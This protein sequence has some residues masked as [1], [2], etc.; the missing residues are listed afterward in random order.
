MSAITARTPAGRTER[1]GLDLLPAPRIS[2]DLG[3]HDIASALPAA[4][5]GIVQ[6]GLLDRAFQDSLYPE[7]IFPNV[8]DVMPWV[9]NVGD[10]KIWTRTGLMTPTP[11]PVAPGADAAADTYSMEQWKSI[12]DTYGRSIDTNVLQSAVSLGNKYLQDVMTLGV[13]A[14][15]SMNQAARNTLYNA[16]K[17]GRT[18]VTSVVT[19]TTIPVKDTVGFG[20]T[21]VNG[22]LTAVSASNP[23]TVTING[24]TNT[25]TAI[26]VASGPGNLTVGTSITTAVGH[27]VVAA[28]APTSIRPTGGSAYDLSAGNIATLSLFR[29]AYTRLKKMNIPMI[30]GG[31]TAFVTEDT[32]NQLYSDADFKLALTGQVESP[33]WRDR[34]IGRI[35]GIDFVANN[36]VPTV[37]GGSAGTLTVNQ[38]LVV[39]AGAIVW[40]PLENLGSLLAGTGVESV[41]SISMVSP[42][43]GV[44][45]ALIVRPPTDRFQNLVSTT[46]QTV[47][48]YGTPTDLLNAAGDAALMKRAVLV[49]HA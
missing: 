11:T 7:W 41:P 5:Q 49:Q 37:L 40:S 35:N 3:A 21:S 29:S 30:G 36:E 33:V 47:G 1:H 48:G 15:Q 8:C 19:S 26:S 32:I 43:A 22:V 38:C 6:K 14:G 4:I 13:H 12:L 18:Y 17:G 25:V 9:G 23:L 39:G 16:Y 45:V 31:Y 46:W 34:A 2:M 42:A 44:D 24:V 27:T 10:E 20:F 28:N